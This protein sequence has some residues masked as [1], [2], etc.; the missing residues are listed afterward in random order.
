MKHTQL[1]LQSVKLS[2]RSKSGMR[3]EWQTCMVRLGVWMHG[4]VAHR[5]CSILQLF[6]TVWVTVY[7]VGRAEERISWVM[8]NKRMRSE[9]DGIFKRLTSLCNY[10][11]VYHSRNHALS[12]VEIS[13]YHY[14][15]ITKAIYIA[16]HMPLGKRE[17][18]RAQCSVQTRLFSIRV[19]QHTFCWGN[20]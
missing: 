11:L 14:T 9:L 5:S 17:L 19:W 2:S 1:H 8:V 12:E 6:M 7:T 4:H 13:F 18:M 15:I 16:S 10:W 3:S 20:W